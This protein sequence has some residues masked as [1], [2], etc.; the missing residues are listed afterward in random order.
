M[1]KLKLNVMKRTTETVPQY[2]RGNNYPAWLPLF[3]TV[4]TTVMIIL[5]TLI[6]Y[7]LTR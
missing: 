1:W 2:K 4:W 7:K 6:I 5:W 3:L